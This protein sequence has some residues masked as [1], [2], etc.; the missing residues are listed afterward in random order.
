[1]QLLLLLLIFVIEGCSNNS[2]DI[3][4]ETYTCQDKSFT[5]EVPSDYELDVNIIGGY[6]VFTKKDKNGSDAAFLTIERVTDGFA[7]FD[8]GLTT[9]KL[10]FDVYKESDNLKFAECSKGMWSAVQLGML[11][12]IDDSQYLIILKVQCARS[13]PEQIIQHIYDSMV[14][15]TPIV[16]TG[17]EDSG[18]SEFATYTNPYL[19][20]DYPKDWTIVKNPDSMSDVYIGAQKEALGFTIVR[21]DT[22]ESFEQIIAEAQAGSDAAGMKTTENKNITIN[23]MQCNRM[24]N[25]FEYDGM[26]VKTIAYTFK[27]DKTLYSVKFGTQKTAVE[28]HID[29]IETLMKSFKIK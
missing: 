5:V 26:P 19:S 8:K 14:E 24:V 13:E 27:R 23:G 21:F 10:Q 18:D 29:L 7:S 1:M 17:K 25:E 15:G 16:S 28:A 20:I 22:D 4:W 3:T 2:S 6:M 9:G 12:T 11:K